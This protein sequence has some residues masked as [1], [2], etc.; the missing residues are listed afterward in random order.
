MKHLLLTAALLFA[1]PAFSLAPI[2]FTDVL[3]DE[4]GA[5]L[6]TGIQAAADAKVPEFTILIDSPG[7]SVAEELLVFAALR[8]ADH[9]GVKS[10][11]IVL[12][13][14]MAASAAAVIFEGCSLRIMAPS[15]RLLFHEVRVGGVQGTKGDMARLAERMEDLDKEVATMFAWR[16]GMSANSYL[17]WIS[18]R[19]QWLDGTGA[20]ERQ[21]ADVVE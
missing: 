17:A 18:G 19:D 13:D 16:L 11:Y 3:D 6:L 12:P 5:K 1:L 10:R 2:E 21:A 20:L 8:D 15:S 14:G 4:M 9:K 7:G